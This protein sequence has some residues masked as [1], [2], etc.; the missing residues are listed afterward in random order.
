MSLLKRIFGLESAEEKSRPPTPNDLQEAVEEHKEATK[1]FE[2]VAREG[3]RQ[4]AALAAA[5]EALAAA[6]RKKNH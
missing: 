4:N 6:V 2:K 1:G 5:A 3:E